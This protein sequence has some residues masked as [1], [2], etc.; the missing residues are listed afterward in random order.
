MLSIIQRSRV[1]TVAFRIY[2][3]QVAKIAATCWLLMCGVCPLLVPC[4]LF[5]LIRWTVPLDFSLESCYWTH[6][7]AWF[8]SFGVPV[9][10]ASSA[11]LKNESIETFQ[12]YHNYNPQNNSAIYLQWNLEIPMLKC[13]TSEIPQI[14]LIINSPNLNIGEP[15]RQFLH[16]EPR[17]FG[18]SAACCVDVA[19]CD[20]AKP[21]NF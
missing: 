2:L 7:I 1:N 19:R 5:S 6:V 3:A 14:W 10:A 18:S 12:V 9:S 16:S 17:T 20:W 11:T 4:P 21:C 8:I 13:H 15:F